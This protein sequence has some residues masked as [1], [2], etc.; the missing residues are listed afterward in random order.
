MIFGAIYLGHHAVT[1]HKREKQRVKNYERWEG[2]RDE[3]D[4]QRKISRET[5]SLDI[6]RTGAY[7]DPYGQEDKPILT[8]RD[9]QEADD[10]RTGWRP[11]ESWT[12]PQAPQ[13]TGMRTGMAAARPRPQSMDLNGAY[14]Q[15]AVSDIRDYSSQGANGVGLQPQPTGSP[16]QNPTMRKLPAQ[17][18]GSNWDDGLPQPIRVSRQSFNDSADSL[19]SGIGRSASMREYGSGRSSESLAVPKRNINSRSPSIPEERPKEVEAVAYQQPGGLM[20]DLIE[21]KPA[22]NGY[23][24]A[25]ASGPTYDQK[26]NPFANMDGNRPA[27]VQAAQPSMEEWW[28]RPTEAKAPATATATERDMQEWWR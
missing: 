4:E 26:A 8:L 24:P 28:Q 13:Q 2:L 15:R 25:P 12:G 11:Q 22:S 1:A 16:Y 7:G 20:A 23:Q 3:Y 14:G 9:Q 6:Q 10:A 5:R 19:G 18:T 21:G 17:M 27:P